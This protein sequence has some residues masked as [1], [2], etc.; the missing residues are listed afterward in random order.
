MTN[1][2]SAQ[3]TLQRVIPLGELCQ[4]DRHVISPSAPE[5]PDLPYVGLE[6]IE[7]QTGRI[8]QPLGGGIKSTGFRFDNRHVLYGRLR[9]YLNKIA[10]PDFSG[11]CSSEIIPLLPRK[12]ESR[13]LLACA[14][15]QPAVVDFAVHNSTGSR[16]PRINIERLLEFPVYVPDTVAERKRLGN[17]IPANLCRAAKM[18]MAMQAQAEMIAAL[19]NSILGTIFSDDKKSRQGWTIA[20]LA[21]I[22]QINPH[23]PSDFVRPLDNT[24]TAFVPMSAVNAASGRANPILRPYAEVRQGYTF[25]QS[26]DVLFAR[27]TPCMQNGK[28][29]IAPQT[30]NGFGFAS[31]EFHVIRPGIQVLAEWIHFYLR[32]LIVLFEATRHFTGTVGQQRVPADFLQRLEIPFAP[33]SEQRIITQTLK[34]KMK[35]T[36]QLNSAAQAQLDAVEALPAAL[37]HRAFSSR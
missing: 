23:R 15:R 36:A 26:G 37:L 2:Q 19:P 14:L 4:V 27:I 31:T 9:P 3:S 17:A 1:T 11:R 10:I 32:Q 33:L 28:H 6:H 24:P 25:F 21:E 34:A 12:G 8:L 18:K 30:P 29:F 22:A 5:F 7:A 13:N 20:P 16:M 35:I